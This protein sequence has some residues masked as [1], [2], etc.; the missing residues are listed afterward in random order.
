MISVLLYYHCYKDKN[1]FKQDADT[2]M[3]TTFVT[4]IIWFAFKFEKPITTGATVLVRQVCG[5]SAGLT[6]PRYQTDYEYY[7]IS[8]PKRRRIT[9]TIFSILSSSPP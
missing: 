7:L 1:D 3:L 5:P 2:T 4:T 6:W 8:Y 9:E